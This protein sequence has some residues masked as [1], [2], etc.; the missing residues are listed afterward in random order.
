M[1]RVRV[2]SP[3]FR[4]V[5]RGPCARP[6][7]ACRG[8]PHTPS[9][10]N[11]GTC[12]GEV[13]RERCVRTVVARA[14]SAM[15]RQRESMARAVVR[16]ATFFQPH[17]PV[18]IH[19]AAVPVRSRQGLEVPCATGGSHQAR[20]RRKACRLRS[21]RLPPTEA[22]EWG[23]G[24]PVTVPLRGARCASIARMMV[25]RHQFGRAGLPPPGDDGNGPRTGPTHCDGSR[26]PGPLKESLRSTVLRTTPVGRGR[27]AVAHQPGAPASA[28][29][30]GPAAPAPPPCR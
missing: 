6:V 1:S 3:A 20:A 4:S 8:A 25:G 30:V 27:R 22:I 26:R 2:P 15:P 14:A 19:R 5:R 7:R 23:R 18:A 11:P 28:S 10:T 17:A 21:A 13:R 9:K 12:A 24:V 16:L 29:S